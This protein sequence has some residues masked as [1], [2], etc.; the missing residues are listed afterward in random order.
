V[1]GL[2]AD[3][4]R[5]ARHGHPRQRLDGAAGAEMPADPARAAAQQIDLAAVPCACRPRPCSHA[6]FS[7]RLRRRLAPRVRVLRHR[8]GQPLR[9]CSRRDRAPGRRL[10]HSAGT[11]RKLLMDLGE[12]AGRF[13]F[14]IRDRAGQF[15]AAFDAVF[16][17]AGIEAV[18][19]P[20]RSP[21]AN[22]LRRTLGRHRPGRGDRPDAHHRAPAPACR[23]GSLRR[24]LQLPS[25][26]PGQKPD[27]DESAPPQAPT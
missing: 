16:A 9:P 26:A 8:G 3:P 15:T 19:V 6:T 10:D 17:G 18:K 4:G 14:L 1:L 27:C 5:T 21:S 23:P 2:P 12:R 22:A 24:P 11:A 25:P 13:R 20:P 7:C